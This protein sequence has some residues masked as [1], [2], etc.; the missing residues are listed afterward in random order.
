MKNIEL[1][2]RNKSILM[3]KTF[4]NQANFAEYLFEN[5]PFNYYIKVVE[6]LVSFHRT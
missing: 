4:A 2:F 3:F 6:Y 1:N 5:D